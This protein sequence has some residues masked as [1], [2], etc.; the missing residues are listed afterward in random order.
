MSDEE[1]GAHVCKARFDLGFVSFV[2]GPCTNLRT[3]T[4]DDQVV[5]LV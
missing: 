2:V 3:W 1:G 4:V 5:V